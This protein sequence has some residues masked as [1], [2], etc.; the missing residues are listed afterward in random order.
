MPT[1]P[2]RGT[3]LLAAL[4]APAALVALVALACHHAPPPDAGDAESARAVVDAADG[5]GDAAAESVAVDVPAGLLRAS[6]VHIQFAVYYLPKARVDP[7]A[8]VRAL[9]EAKSL[10]ILTELPKTPPDKPTVTVLTPTIEELPPPP[11][12]AIKYAE[13]GLDEATAEA[14]LASRQVT[15]L[16]FADKGDRADALLQKALRVAGALA[17]RGGGLPWDVATRQVLSL[18]AWQERVDA[19]ENGVPIAERQTRIDMYR[20]GT[21][22]RL[23]TLGMQKMD[24]PDLAVNGVPGNEAKSM[25]SLLNLLSQAV[26]ERG[27]LVEPGVFD[28]DIDGVESVAARKIEVGGG[29]K[30]HAH[31]HLAIGRR[32]EGDAENRLMD[33]VFPGPPEALHERQYAAITELFGASDGGAKSIAEPTEG[34]AGP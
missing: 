6:E 9:P 18:A 30:R 34:G 4:V 27:E 17:R 5:G 11:R 8:T 23:V 12:E 24:L 15:F 26:V 28:L 21:L 3:S 13:R 33:V 31:L 7:L 14:F 1:P 19:F 25:V 10:T 2:F 22:L 32:Q 16:A 20:D 29:A